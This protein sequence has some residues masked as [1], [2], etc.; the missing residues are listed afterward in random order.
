M[1]N[2]VLRAINHIKYVSKKKPCT[3]KIFNY[4]QNNGA[5]NY[6]YESVEN[7]IAELRNDGIIDETF[8]RTN[9]IEEVLNFPEDDVDITSGNSDISCL[10]TQSSQVDEENDATPSLNNNTLTPNPQGVFPSDFETL[11]Q[12]L[13]DKLNGKISAIKSYLLDEVY[14]LKNELKVLQDNYLTENPD[15]NEKEEICAL[16]QK[17]KTLEVQNQ[18]LR[19][20]VVS[21]QNLIDSLPEHNSN[22]LSHQCCRV[23]QDTQS[24]VRS[25]I[26]TDVTDNHSNNHGVNTITN[27]K[28]NKQTTSY[29]KNDK[30]TV[31]NYN[32]D[33][34]LIKRQSANNSAVK[35]EAFYYRR[36]DDKVCKWAR[37]F[38]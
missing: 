27:E 7:E 18:F 4:L 28:T 35:K 29:K 17:V 26:N 16:K 15:S 31:Y 23:I 38:S 12:S 10:N 22:L 32:D 5:S 37:S 20:D 13:E 11:F 30:T 19:N 24:N 9:P 36:L 25:G 2:Q 14:D 21:K 6:N 34:N 3:L 1:D 8:K 33:S